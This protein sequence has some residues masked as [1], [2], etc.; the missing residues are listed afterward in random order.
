MTRKAWV[1]TSAAFVSVGVLAGAIGYLAGSG[2]LKKS[3]D[4]IVGGIPAS[5]VEDSGAEEDPIEV[6]I[7]E[8]YQNEQASVTANRLNCAANAID[9]Y[10]SGA[11]EKMQ[12]LLSVASADEAEKLK[13]SQWDWLTSTQ[14]QLS[15]MNSVRAGAAGTM[16]TEMAAGVELAMYRQRYQFMSDLAYLKGEALCPAGQCD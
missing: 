7:A 1:I 16:F 4:F 8:C 13:T 10:K 2:A 3:D 9:L 5:A 12:Y 15:A 14:S 6:K 11:Q